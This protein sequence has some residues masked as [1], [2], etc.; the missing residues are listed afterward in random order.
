MAILNTKEAADRLGVGRVRVRQLIRQGKIEAQNLGR[1]YAIEESALAF[2][3]V[4]RR[5][6]RPAK[7]QQGVTLDDIS[8]S[9]VTVE[10]PI[11]PARKTGTRAKAKAGKKGR[12]SSKKGGAK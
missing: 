1:D 5:R 3:T 8:S 9:S 12:K 2:V 10:L 6:G 11:A 4:Y 7:D